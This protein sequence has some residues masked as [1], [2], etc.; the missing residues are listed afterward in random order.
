MSSEWASSGRALMRGHG[1]LF[2]HGRFVGQGTCGRAGSSKMF[3]PGWITAA[4]R[5]GD[6]VPLLECLDGALTQR[7]LGWRRGPPLR[8]KSG[9][10]GL[11]NQQHQ[12][13]RWRLKL[14]PEHP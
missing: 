12:V 14:Q 11:A 3:S 1:Q 9:P 4:G 5:R 6:G 2:E 13:R 10:G 8:P 7:R